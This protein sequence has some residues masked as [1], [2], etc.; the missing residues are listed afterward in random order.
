MDNERHILDELDPNRGQESGQEEMQTYIGCKIIMARPMDE[1][2]FLAS[3]GKQMTSGGYS[4]GYMVQY[5]DGYVSWSPKEVFEEAYR[6]VNDSETIY[7]S[8]AEHAD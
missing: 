6:L 4:A 2:S 7:I 5:P 3:Q 8:K 1:D